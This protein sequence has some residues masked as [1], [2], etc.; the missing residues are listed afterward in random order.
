MPGRVVRATW[1]VHVVRG[2]SPGGGGG[3]EREGR[4]FRAHAASHVREPPPPLRSLVG[5]S[6]AHENARFFA[7]TGTLRPWGCEP[8]PGRADAHRSAARSTRVLV[9]SNVSRR[10]VPVTAHPGRAHPVSRTRG[11]S[12]KRPSGSMRLLHLAPSLRPDQ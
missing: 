11:C 6:L 9:T 4:V 7:G 12:H 5:C 8:P 1:G 3:R 10:A 2:A